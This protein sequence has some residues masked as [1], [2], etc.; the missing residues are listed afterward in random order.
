MILVT[1]VLILI[2]WGV[3]ILRQPCNINNLSIKAKNGESQIVVVERL[4]TVWLG[5][6]KRQHTCIKSWLDNYQINEIKLNGSNNPLENPFGV[7]VVYSVKPKFKN[8]FDF[9]MKDNGVRENEW[10]KNMST[11]LLIEKE[12]SVYKIKEIK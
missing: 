1:V 3:S 6:Y 11:D 4:M 10:I 9:W 12:E 8:G 2:I 7:S 5:S